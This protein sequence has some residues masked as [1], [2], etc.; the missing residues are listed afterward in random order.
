M[1]FILCILIKDIMN[2]R[3]AL[4]QWGGAGGGCAMKTNA[5]TQPKN[6]LQQWPLALQL[7]LWCLL[8]NCKETA[9]ES[10]KTAVTA[11][12]FNGFWMWHIHPPSTFFWEIFYLYR[13][14]FNIYMYTIHTWYVLG[15]IL[16]GTII[17]ITFLGRY[18]K[19]MH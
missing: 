6:K 4:L 19:E 14:F 13:Y 12:G 5:V 17:Q 18:S 16:L 8:R 10:P 15:T 7:L 11:V 3:V 2:S 9:V 1:Y